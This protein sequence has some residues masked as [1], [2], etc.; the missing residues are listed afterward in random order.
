MPDVFIIT[1]ME[2]F[3]LIALDEVP[4]SPEKPSLV[5]AIE[6]SEVDNLL[7]IIKF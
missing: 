7:A 6:L 2:S 5:E 3:G 4:A 1:T